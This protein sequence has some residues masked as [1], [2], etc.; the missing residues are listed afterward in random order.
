MSILYS[1]LILG[2]IFVGILVLPDSFTA[3][4]YFTIAILIYVIFA[5]IVTIRKF[6]FRFLRFS[7]ASI[8]EQFKYSLPLG[9]AISVELISKFTDMIIVSNAVSTADFSIFVNGAFEIP[10]VSLISGAA[11]AILFPEFVK[12]YRNHNFQEIAVRWK[13][14]IRKTSTFLIPTMVFFLTF[15]RETMVS[16]YSTTYANSTNIFFLY[17]FILP[18]RVTIISQVISAFNKNR[19]ALKAILVGLLLNLTLTYFLVKYFGMAGAPIG[20]IVSLYMIN[21]Y[22]LSAVKKELNVTYASLLPV[23]H[24]LKLLI[25]SVTIALA[26]RILLPASIEVYIYLILAALIFFSS[27]AAVVITG[28][29]VSW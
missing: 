29:V 21:I 28:K 17:L 10:F 8:Y 12:Y 23:W 4:K 25:L 14:S 18:L 24:T 7:F 27:V 19:L 13:N 1:V 16:M 3:I 22:L 11:M 2:G 5:L 6:P 26:V 20:T 9:L 15:P